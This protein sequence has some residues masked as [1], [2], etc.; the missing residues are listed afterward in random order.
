[1][2]EVRLIDANAL[3]VHLERYE[4]GQPCYLVYKSDIDSAPTVPAEVVRHGRW[5]FE[6]DTEKDPKRLFVRIECSACGLKTGLTSA[7][8]PNCGARMDQDA[9]EEE[10]G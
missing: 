3:P 9:K 8:C 1:M 10:H 6:H 2:N 4:Y 7:Y 5:I